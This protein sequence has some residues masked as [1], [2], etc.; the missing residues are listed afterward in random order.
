M[1]RKEIAMLL[2]LILVAI[3]SNSRA[4]SLWV[5][6]SSS[7]KST[8]PN[9]TILEQDEIKALIAAEKIEVI[10]IDLDKNPSSK[11]LLK[12]L[13]C[14]TVP[15]VYQLSGDGNIRFVAHLLTPEILMK[16]S[17]EVSDVEDLLG[18]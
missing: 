12:S 7:S 14:S 9:R 1:A 2:I 18:K 10:Y 3:G 5:F 8:E 6:E 17:Q 4:D 13:G 16:I 11:M 15:A